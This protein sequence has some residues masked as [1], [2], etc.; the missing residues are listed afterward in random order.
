MT[1]IFT[2]W[3]RRNFSS[4][5]TIVLTMLIIVGFF[6]I[7]TVGVGRYSVTEKR[8]RPLN[9]GFD[10]VYSFYR[11]IDRY[12]FGPSAFDLEARIKADRRITEYYAQA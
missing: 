4:P 11:H 7:L 3:F 6:I 5:A 10:G 12:L 9:L 8:I 1:S 2:R